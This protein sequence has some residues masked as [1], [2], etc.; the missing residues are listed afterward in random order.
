MNKLTIYPDGQVIDDAGAVIFRSSV[1]QQHARE[2]VHD[3][4][5]QKGYSIDEEW[6]MDDDSIEVTINRN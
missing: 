5:E 1:S 2:I 3:T 4:I 6:E